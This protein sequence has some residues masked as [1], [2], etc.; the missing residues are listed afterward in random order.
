MKTSK[1]IA[2]LQQKRRQLLD[3]LAALDAVRRGSMTEQFVETTHPDGSKSRRGPYPLYS[4]KDKAETV[5]RRVPDP[6]QAAVYRQQIDE[7]HRPV[8]PADSWIKIKM[9]L[10]T[11]MT[12]ASG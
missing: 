12:P 3:Q 4:Y 6:K 10:R 9:I 7:N 1:Q 5:S 8:S 11:S 2:Q